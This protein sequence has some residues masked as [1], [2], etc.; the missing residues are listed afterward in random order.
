MAAEEF[1]KRLLLV[2][3]LLAGEFDAGR[4]LC[5]RDAI[6]RAAFSAGRL[7]PGIALLHDNG[8]A[9]HGFADQAL[10]LFTHRLLRHPPAPVMGTEPPYST[11]ITSCDQP[12][13]KKLLL[14]P[15]SLHRS[16]RIRFP[17]SNSSSFV[18]RFQLKLHLQQT[19]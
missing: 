18:A 7:D 15:A 9:R 5:G 11:D 1:L 4:A 2:S 13:A 6:W 16:V 14:K 8:L 17:C 10:G 12:V 3:A 19:V